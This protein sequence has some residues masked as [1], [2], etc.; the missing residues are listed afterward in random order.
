MTLLIYTLAFMAAGLI[1]LA[2]AWK[3]V[4]LQA[5]HPAFRGLAV[6]LNSRRAKHTYRGFYFLFRAAAKLVLLLVSGV[7]AY[8]AVRSDECEE[9]QI[10]S[11]GNFWYRPRGGSWYTHSPDEDSTEPWI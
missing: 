9:T 8:I 10:D 4:V 11:N 1:L 7:L 3:P 2:I 6:H 5:M